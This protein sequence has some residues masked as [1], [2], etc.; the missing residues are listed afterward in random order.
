MTVQ[1]MDH[2]AMVYK[3]EVQVVP[4][5]AYNLVQGLPW[6]KTRK[7]EI[8]RATARLTSLCTPS[9]QGEACRSGM[10]EQRYKRRGDEI[11]TVWLPDIGGSMPT[12]NLTSEMALDPD[13]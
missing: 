1:Y 7:P 13:G 12:I 8:D 6:F 5:R 3:T 2:L 9:G 4:M 11:T 10:T